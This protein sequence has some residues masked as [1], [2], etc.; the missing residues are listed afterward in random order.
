M[1]I[2]SLAQALLNI[3]SEQ[4]FSYTIHI[5]WS[6]SAVEVLDKFNKHVFGECSWIT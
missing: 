1:K 6:T 2:L 3:T 5:K 4:N